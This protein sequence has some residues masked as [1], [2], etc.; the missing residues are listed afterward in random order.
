[1]EVYTVIIWQDTVH[2]A[3]QDDDIEQ[4]PIPASVYVLIKIKNKKILF[5]LQ[6]ADIF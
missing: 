3:A 5:I 4:Y 6:L 2:N 1:M